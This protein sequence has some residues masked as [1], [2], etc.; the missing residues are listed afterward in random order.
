M[1]LFGRDS[2]LTSW[3]TLLVDPDL[4]LGTL[5]TLARYQGTA[6]DPLTEEE[7]G[8]IPHELRWGG[9]R[10]P[11]R[12]QS[13]LYYGTVDAT[14]LF[15]MLLGELWRW[16]V[17]PQAVD[18]LLPH[19]D[20]AL[21]WLATDG[22]RDG[23]GLVEYRRAT[24]QGLAN[25]GWKDSW[26]GI[27]FA[28]GRLPDTPVALCEVQGYAYAAYLARAELAAGRGD[29][30]GE[31]RFEDEAA[32][33]KARF[34]EAF[35]LA[36]EGTFAVGLDREKRPIDS[37]TSNVG[38]CL[39]TGIVDEAKA[40]A[41]AAR[42][43]GADMLTGFGL[44]TLSSAMHAYNPVSY[45]NGSVWPH[46]NAIAVAGLARYG[47]AAEAEAVVLGLLDAAASFRGRLPELFCGFDRADFG[48]PVPY[49][50]ACSPQAWA[51]AAPYLVVR[52]LLGLDPALQRGLLRI[53]PIVPDRI[54]DLV[55]EH[56][57][58][59]GSRLAIRV[60]H[61]VVQVD[62]LPPGVAVEQGPPR[63]SPG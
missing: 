27:S 12:G 9:V 26:D 57:P 36:K 18:E 5:Q 35:W 48:T 15:V 54:G 22:D 19:A 6:Y 11:S 28:D 37:V 61:G 51:T 60:H 39:W 63:P 3:M 44:R 20:R 1:T 50:S 53:D 62:G 43:L 49:P 30:E 31:R 55:L 8:R 38:H 23:D 13:G 34:N 2:L 14:P 59:G 47:F 46:D 41:V 45:H 17:S 10:S 56:I 32:R 33:L 40:P 21:E 29:R 7:P 52:A 42:L 4:A 58:L 24:D 16:G 25:Q